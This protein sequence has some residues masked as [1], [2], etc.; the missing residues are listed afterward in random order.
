MTD[1]KQRVGEFLV[2]QGFLSQGDVDR[3]L[4]HA[5]TQKIR[6]GEAAVQLKVLSR[7]H[8]RDVFGSNNDVDFVSLRA[9][10]FPQ[11]TKLILPVYEML[12]LGALPLGFDFREQ[13]KREK[14]FKLGLLNPGSK[15]NL[16]LAQGLLS[17][18]LA[19]ESVDQIVVYLILPDQFLDILREVY[20]I[21]ETAIQTMDAAKLDATLAAFVKLQ[22]GSA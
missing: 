3:V 11:D 22:I 14:I 2:E 19:K 7:E 17:E 1:K 8:L 6:F 21:Y 12:K 10:A 18:G 5:Q 9:E 20:Q 16:A 13:P 15:V 4:A